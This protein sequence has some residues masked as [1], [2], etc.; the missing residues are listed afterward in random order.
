MTAVE[1]AVI[2]VEG[3]AKQQSAVEVFSSLDDEEVDLLASYKEVR[4]RVVNGHRDLR[5]EGRGGCMEQSP[6]FHFGGCFF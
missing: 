6:P 3:T 2:S 1:E 4:P 5:A